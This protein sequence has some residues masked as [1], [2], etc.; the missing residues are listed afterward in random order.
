MAK[1]QK[2]V[3]NEVEDLPKT[4]KEFLQAKEDLAQFKELHEVVFKEFERLVEVYNTCLESA[5]KLARSEG[6]SMGPFKVKNL[7]KTY[8]FEKLAELI[9]LDTFLSLGGTKQT[10]EVFA[11]EPEALQAGIDC[12]LIKPEVVKEVCATISVFSVPSKIEVG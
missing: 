1:N 10:K 3:A 2:K 12:G 11:L 4:V 8:N 7:R 5:E 9:G 6:L